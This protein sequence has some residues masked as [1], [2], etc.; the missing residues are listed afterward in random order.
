MNPETQKVRD[1]S[2]L[3]NSSEKE[4]TVIFVSLIQ[5]LLWSSTSGN[6]L[7]PNNCFFAA[8]FL[9]NVLTRKGSREWEYNFQGLKSVLSNQSD[10]CDKTTIICSMIESHFSPL[11]P[12]SNPQKKETCRSLIYSIFYRKKISGLIFYNHVFLTPA[13]QLHW[14]Q[15]GAS[16]FFMT[17]FYLY[18]KSN[19]FYL[20]EIYHIFL[21]KESMLIATFIIVWLKTKT[22]CLLLL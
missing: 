16:L 4:L 5:T 13:H 8:W 11:F 10:F 9:W 17:I 18:K 6:L 3:F 19:Y 2:I 15:E 20:S 1:N 7:H 21:N 12:I 14:I 22:L